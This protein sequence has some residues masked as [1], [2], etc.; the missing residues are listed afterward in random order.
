M[1]GTVF[2]CENGE[3]GED[4]LNVRVIVVPRCDGEEADIR[5][6]GE[7]SMV[8]MQYSSEIISVVSVL[9]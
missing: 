9:R 3:R 4:R 6:W 1:H 2:R 8:W 7:W 5:C